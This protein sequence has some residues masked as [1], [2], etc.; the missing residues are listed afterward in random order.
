ML[1]G[2]IYGLAILHLG[3]GIAFAVLAF[4][5]DPVRPLLGAV[6]RTDALG[7]FMG[8]TL[9]LWI[10]LGVAAVALAAFR[11]REATRAPVPA[12]IE[13]RGGRPE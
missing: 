13:G 12:A 4:G 9:T 2:L 8:L 11:R 10:V 6:C 7:A 3:P 5:C 1:R